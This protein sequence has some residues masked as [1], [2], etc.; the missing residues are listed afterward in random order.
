MP[1]TEVHTYVSYDYRVQR[2]HYI[3]RNYNEGGGYDGTGGLCGH[4]L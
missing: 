4:R 3:N 2:L 1:V